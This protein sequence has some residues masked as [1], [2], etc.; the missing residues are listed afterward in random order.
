MSLRVT[1]SLLIFS[2]SI[3]LA[4]FLENSVNRN[5][6]DDIPR[7]IVCAVWQYG[8]LVAGLLF[9]LVSIP[10]LFK[11]LKSLLRLEGSFSRSDPLKVGFLALKLLP[12]IGYQAL[13]VIVA[14]ISPES[15][16][17][18]SFFSH[19]I[20][21]L[22]G[23]TLVHSLNALFGVRLNTVLQ[24]G[25][26]LSERVANVVSAHAR[27]VD[28][29]SKEEIVL[30]RAGEQV[31]VTGIV[32][33]GEGYFT[34]TDLRSPTLIS[35]R[36]NEGKRSFFRGLGT[37]AKS[38]YILRKGEIYLSPLR[39]DDLSPESYFDSVLAESFNKPAER[40]SIISQ[41]FV[42]G[43]NIA[44]ILG[45]LLSI[46]YVLQNGNTITSWGAVSRFFIILSAIPSIW[47][48]LIYLR[49]VRNL[50]LKALRSYRIIVPRPDA[51][52]GFAKL[53]SLFFVLE[54]PPRPT[55]PQLSNSAFFN[56][57]V[58]EQKI[59]YL[60][61]LILERVREQGNSN[62]LAILHFLEE[63]H[64]TFK[65]G[66]DT[67]LEITGFH[68]ERGKGIYSEV[69]ESGQK[70]A[71]RIL[72]GNEEFILNNFVS[73]NVSD[74]AK[75]RSE[76]DSIY[77][78]LEGQVLARF[79]I[80]KRIFLEGSG[81]VKE[82]RQAGLSINL[83]SSSDPQSIDTLGTTFGFELAEIQGGLN[84]SDIVPR[85]I[86]GAPSLCFTEDLS[87]VDEIKLLSSPLKPIFSAGRFSRKFWDAIKTDCTIDV[88]D[89]ALLVKLV[90]Y[91]KEVN[92]GRIALIALSILM[93]VSV[94]TM[95]LLSLFIIDFTYGVTYAVLGIVFY[96]IILFGAVSCF[97][98]KVRT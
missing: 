37:V 94:V 50:V 71:S 34:E 35:L 64:D 49:A 36:R 5:F 16:I 1:F 85:L 63:R 11:Y 18:L 10:Y 95:S 68:W 4:Y 98:P 74:V 40:E 66:V 72:F 41:F 13:E 52:F 89:P 60:V 70:N 53:K 79:D 69:K 75:N 31:P 59:L 55:L 44:L 7:E 23:V 15:F 25:L 91:A 67:P 21:Y 86:Q 57:G 84:R 92:Y 9:S 93:V 39:E 61:R 30:V 78:V 54:L 65:H 80:E 43:G 48:S 38:S 2:T 22:S 77:F 83:L 46:I 90:A 3:V 29:L 97:R 42:I 32:V 28:E 47:L 58:A 17:K 73:L 33:N 6:N 82:A 24:N 27:R 88:D 56:D 19:S 26:T 12:L 45:V 96:E 14:V 81:V 76:V 20:I 62:Y 51:L 8:W 87:L